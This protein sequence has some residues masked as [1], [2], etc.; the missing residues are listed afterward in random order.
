MGELLD[1]SHDPVGKDESNL[2]V[3]LG[4]LEIQYC[5][6][7]SDLNSFQSHCEIKVGEG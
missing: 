5:D 4:T 6:L 2:K 7:V 3:N 1:E